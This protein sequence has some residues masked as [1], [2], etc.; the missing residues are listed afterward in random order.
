MVNVYSRPDVAQALAR[1]QA[2]GSKARGPLAVP[3]ARELLNLTTTV[4]CLSF[5]SD[6]Q[7]RRGV[8]W[9]LAT[10]SWH[11]KLHS[12]APQALILTVRHHASLFAITHLVTAHEQPL[13]HT[14]HSFT[15]HEWRICQ[16]QKKCERLGWGPL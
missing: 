13:C 6:T 16:L 10:A 11:V 7:V 8:R 9:G 2:S 4:D 12:L 5:N 15:C 3:P 1:S 14:E